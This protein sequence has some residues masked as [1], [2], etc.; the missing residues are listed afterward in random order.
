MKFSL[1]TMFAI[2]AAVV[3]VSALGYWTFW[4]SPMLVDVATVETGPLSVTVD[5]DGKTRIKERYIVSSPLSGRLLRIDLD[6]G[7]EVIAG[8]TLIAT[9]EP[10]DPDLLD[11][12]ALAH[13][14][15]K[16][17]AT[18]AALQKAEPEVERTRVAMQ[19]A[20]S[21]MRRIT[22]LYQR[23]ASSESDFEHAELLLRTRRQEHK[24][25]QF[26]QEIAGFELEMA[27][28]ALLHSAPN[29]ENG[30]PRLD[31]KI[32]APISG[33]VLR[34]FQE[35]STVLAAGAK[36]VELGD[37]HDLEVEVDVLSKDAV[38]IAP[39]A[40]VSLE[41]WGGEEPLTGAVRLV[42]PQA[43]TK[44][45]A[46]GVEEQRVNVVIDFLQP[47]DDRPSLGD[48]FRV[49]ARIVVWQQGQVLKVP[50]SAL[51]RQDEAWATFVRANGKA[52]LRQVQVGQRNNMEAEV[53]EGLSAGD[54]VV[55]HPSEKI[56]HGVRIEPR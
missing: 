3:T 22:G 2:V 30:L 40:S 32:H 45:S 47:P 43:F 46:L 48:G 6:P 52:E 53:L 26:A 41:Q 4:Q 28:A 7:K 15:A 17:L 37:P 54:Q 11:A 24:A 50:L 49:E 51:F 44:I 10:T 31:F 29:E 42:E 55:L 33:R 12:R 5:E 27:Q 8:E 18:K 1:L 9:V 34:V 14:E 23:K 13:A 20:E 35:S 19:Y 36:L 56:K 16:V 39:G 38:R 25:A 21:E